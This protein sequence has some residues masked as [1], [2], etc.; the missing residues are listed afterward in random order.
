MCSELSESTQWAK[1]KPCQ[2]LSANTKKEMNIRDGL[3]RKARRSGS[4]NDWSTYKRKRNQVNNCIKSD[5]RKYY[6]QL[7]KSNSSE[8]KKFWKTIKE[9][10][11][12]NN[13]TNNTTSSLVVNEVETRNDLET[14]NAFCSFFSTIANKLKLAG[15][16]LTNFVWKHQTSNEDIVTRFNFKQVQVSEVLRNLK[17]QKRRS[18]LDL[19]IYRLAFL[20]I[21]QM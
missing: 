7:L 14:A 1:G 5:K 6:R 16:P 18:Q 21:P 17:N 15:F 4:E 20:K 2:W 3:L 11:P 13:V 12:V 8:P 19:T 9:V 10:F